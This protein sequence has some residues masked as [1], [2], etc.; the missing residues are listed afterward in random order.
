MMRPPTMLMPRGRRSSEPVPVP[1]ARGRAPKRA[2]MV[3]IRMGRKR[4]MHASK[5][6]S[7]VLLPPSRSACRAKSIIMMA[8]FLTIPMSRT[9][10]MM[11]MMLRS[12]LKSMRASMA[13]TLAEGSVG[14]MVSQQGASEKTAQGGREAHTLLHLFDGESGVAERDAGSQ[15]ERDGDGGK[16]TGVVDG[17]W[18]GIG[19][20]GGHG[21]EGG[22]AGGS[23]VAACI[24]MKVNVFQ[25]L[26]TLRIMRSDF[27]DD[28]V[29]VQLSVNDGSLGLTERSIDFLI[30]RLRGLAEPC[31]RDAVVVETNIEAA[32]LL[33]GVDVLQGR[34]AFHLRQHARPP[35]G[36]IGNIVGLQGVLIEGR[37]AASADAE[38]L[39]SL[40]E[41]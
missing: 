7:L 17:E 20:T 5:M 29:L 21:D 12:C 26:G 2:A 33:V 8:F 23:D 9:M 30:E 15:I 41:C 31:S 6:A 35:D 24:R 25:A 28:V 16:Q 19:L 3:V 32:I 11:E 13:P 39:G 14:M 1:K 18:D 36:E 22:V 34:Q 10:P 37:A 27:E 4:N 40:K 38:I